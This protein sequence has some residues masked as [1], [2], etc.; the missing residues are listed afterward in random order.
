MLITPSW[1]TDWSSR[2]ALTR[3]SRLLTVRGM[4]RESVATTSNPPADLV[5]KSIRGGAFGIPAQEA[6]LNRVRTRSVLPGELAQVVRNSGLG[7]A[8]HNPLRIAAASRSQG[9]RIDTIRR[10]LVD[11][12]PVVSRRVNRLTRVDLVERRCD[13][14]DRRAV[15]IPTTDAGR[16]LAQ[17]HARRPEE[18]HRR[19]R[20]HRSEAE[21]AA[22]NHLL[23]E[24]GHRDR[25]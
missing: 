25:D 2:E 5:K 7:D 10:R 20:A 3:A 16:R 15:R 12:D 13:P 8:P 24:A 22:L 11:R 18:M 21:L 17:E 19:R 9:V 6:Y 1:E 14:D 4:S 23:L